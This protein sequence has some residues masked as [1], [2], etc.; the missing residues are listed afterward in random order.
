MMV[1]NRHTD[2]LTLYIYAS[3]LAHAHTHT[4]THTRL[5]STC[6]CASVAVSMC[7][8]LCMFVSCVYLGGWGVVEG[9]YVFIL[10]HKYFSFRCVKEEINV[11]TCCEEELAVNKSETEKMS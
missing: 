3:M 11:G 2:T 7:A 4:H 6:V 9:C 1:A 8:H 10:R 5:C